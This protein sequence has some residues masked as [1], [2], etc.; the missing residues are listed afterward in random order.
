MP[1][2][3]KNHARSMENGMTRAREARERFLRSGLGGEQQPE[4]HKKLVKKAR[5]RQSRALE[6]QAKRRRSGRD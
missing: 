1:G 3:Y 4:K 2:G 5:Q 6:R